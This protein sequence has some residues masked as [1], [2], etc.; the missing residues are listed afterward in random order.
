MM[1]EPKAAFAFLLAG[2][3]LILFQGIIYGLIT[4]YAGIGVATIYGAGFWGGLIAM[5]GVVLILFG[6]ILIK[7]AFM[8]GTGEPDKVRSGSIIGIIFGALSIFF[9]GGFY[10]GFILSIVGGILGLTWKPEQPSQSTSQ[11]PTQT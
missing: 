8:V 10:I 3:I 5:L 9:G 7:G 2:G 4:I 6:V 1:T 11:Q